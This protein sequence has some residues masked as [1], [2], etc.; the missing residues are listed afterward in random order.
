MTGI[1]VLSQHLIPP[2][3][4]VMTRDSRQVRRATHIAGCRPRFRLLIDM[5]DV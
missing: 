5:G 2:T 1:A 4:E 3:I